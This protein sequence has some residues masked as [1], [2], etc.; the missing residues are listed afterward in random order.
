M[1]NHINIQSYTI[2]FVNQSFSKNSEHHHKYRQTQHCKKFTWQ[3]N[4]FLQLFCGLKN[5]IYLC[6]VER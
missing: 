2:S 6:T 1:Q 5:N 3:T 4:F